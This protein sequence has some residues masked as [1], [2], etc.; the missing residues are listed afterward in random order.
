MTWQEQLGKQIIEGLY[1]EGMIQTWYRDKPKG[2]IMA[3]KLWTPVYIQLRPLPSSPQ[4]YKLVGKGM[5]KLLNDVGYVP[6]GK[7][8]VVGVASA[9]IPIAD[10]V[11][12]LYGIPALWT[13]KIEGVTN[14]DQLEDYIKRY[15][16]HSLVEG[17]MNNGDILGIVDDLVTRFDSK[18]LAI[19]QVKREAERR[20][21]TDIIVKDVFVLLDREQGAEQKAKELGYSIHSLIPFKSKGIGWLRTKLTKM[22]YEVILDYF[23]NDEKY[24]DEKLQQDLMKMV[25]KV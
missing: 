14:L 9:G 24:Q 15:G 18:L 4:L 21:L 23:S 8:R 1:E 2:W 19:N 5:G 3:S 16:G 17:V 25:K 6:D 20:G 7:H 11:S 12:L 22:E 13:R 10:V